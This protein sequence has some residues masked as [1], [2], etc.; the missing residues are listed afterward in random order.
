MKKGQLTI[1][2]ILGILILIV[3]ASVITISIYTKVKE[4]ET[5]EEKI[6]QDLGEAAQIKSFIDFCL[7]QST[8][9]GLKNVGLNGGYNEIPEAISYENTSFWF[10]DQINTQP[11][12]QEI[13]NRLQ[14]IIEKEISKCLNY[15]RFIE[16]GF[17]INAG[18][19]KINIT[20]GRANTISTLNY[21]I[22]ISKGI[23][24]KQ[25]NTFSTEIKV[26]F[27]QM[28]ETASQVINL[29]LDTDFK[30]FY[31][32]EKLN[33]TIIGVDYSQPQDNILLYTLKEKDQRENE[34]FSL[35]FASKFGPSYL[36][37]SIDL[38]KNSNLVPT[39]LPAILRSVDKMIKLIIMPGTT[40]NLKGEAIKGISVQQAYPSQV[41]RENVPFSEGLEGEV[42]YTNVTWNLTY[43]VYEFEPTGMRFNEPQR[44][45]IHWD[46]SHNPRSGE[47]GI[48]YTEGEGWRPLPSKANYEDN[49]VYTDIPGFSQFAA[50]DCNRQYYKSVSTSAKI[51]PGGGC[52]AKLLITIII[53]I[54]LIAIMVVTFGAATPAEAAALAAYQSA[55]NAGLGVKFATIQA[56]IAALK[57]LEASVIAGS[58]TSSAAISGA[59]AAATSAAAGTIGGAFVTTAGATAT[60]FFGTIG[61]AFTGGLT[62]LGYG[63][64]IAS[65]LVGGMLLTGAMAYGTGHDTITFT[66]TCEQTIE[67]RMSETGGDGLC[68]PKGDEK[69]KAGTP[70]TLKSQMKKCNFLRGMV[71]AQCSVKCS[72]SYK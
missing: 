42:E 8:R 32:L 1:Y 55:M 24:V 18:E 62:L 59:A 37:K 13:N 63:V 25:F 10:V 30:R 72:T 53:L 5:E 67:I 56:E 50:V 12:L 58:M 2:I 40:M 71:C 48:I 31:P 34:E 61:S 68:S 44:L 46:E 65:G 45:V 23:F 26:P 11:T 6:V 33:S 28:F 49:Y 3:L 51:Q 66:P 7:D 64:A 41:I 22:V 69:V 4:V 38:Q 29:Q 15:S 21:E 43:P 54:I 70:V 36:K 19:P 14:E 9:T 57:V 52:I 16:Q 27:R 20:F 17:V 35:V 47:M 39:V 60:G